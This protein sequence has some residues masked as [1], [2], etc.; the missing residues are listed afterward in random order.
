MNRKT[1]SRELEEIGFSDSAISVWVRDADYEPFH[2]LPGAD[3][4]RGR[5][6]TAGQPFTIENILDMLERAA[7]AA[8]I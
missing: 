5:S 3:R 2:C 8:A 7:N 4:A 6:S 1:A